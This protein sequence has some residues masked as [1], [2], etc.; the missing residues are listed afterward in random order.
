MGAGAERLDAQE[1]GLLDLCRETGS[2]RS[3][4]GSSP[5]SGLKLVLGQ[6]APLDARWGSTKVALSFAQLHAFKK[7]CFL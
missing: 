5:L 2:T 3:V 7:G 1:T 4:A 6:D